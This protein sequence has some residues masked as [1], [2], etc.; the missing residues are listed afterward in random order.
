[1]H[2][3][4]SASSQGDAVLLSAA[5]ARPAAGFRDRVKLAW[6]TGDLPYLVDLLIGWR[7]AILTGIGLVALLAFGGF[8][9]LGEV[10]IAK[11]VRQQAAYGQMR[12]GAAD[13]RAD[14]LAMQT[15]LTGFVDQQNPAMDKQLRQTAE[16]A[17][18][19]LR[20]MQGSPAA[21]DNGAALQALQDGLA[22]A[23]T[24]FDKIGKAEQTLGLSDFEGL[25]F[26]LNASIKAMQSELDVWPNQDPL[27]ARMLQMR[28]AEKDFLLTKDAS[29]LGRHKRW[30]NEVDLKIDSGGLDPNT[31]ANFHKLLE[32][33]LADWAAYGETSLAIGQGAA[34]M[35][36][37]F[38]DLQPKVD[39]LFDAAEAASRRANLAAIDIRR[40]ML[41]RTVAMGAISVLVFQLA[42]VIFSRSITVP[43]ADMER[44]MRRLAAGDRNAEISGIGRKDEIGDMAKAVQVFKDNMAAMQQM[45]AERAAQAEALAERGRLLDQLTAEFDRE[46]KAIMQ[47]VEQSMDALH[48]RAEAITDLAG[49]T[50]EQMMQIDDSSRQATEGV[51]S[52]AAAAET[53]AAQVRAINSQVS[54]SSVVTGE[55]SEAASRTDALVAGLSD[56]AQSIGEVVALITAIAHKTHMLALNAT[57][58]SVR[59]GEAGRG[60]AIVA[61]EVKALSTQTSSATGQISSHVAEI[62]ART[63]QAVSAI[64]QI[65]ATTGKIRGN[66][67]NITQAVDYQQSATRDIADNAGRAAEGSV[68]V[69]HKISSAAVQ[70]RG[71]GQAAQDML[72]EAAATAQR[73]D[74]LRDKVAVFL[75]EVA[76]LRA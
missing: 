6:R 63:A 43:I 22:A 19:T 28:L 51:N 48:E 14:L 31:R 54:D 53:L 4:L 9:G 67:D 61:Q 11:A 50:S 58:E 15:A 20:A 72:R 56:S 27:V 39:G 69:S 46:A 42:A 36:K 35:R 33:Y 26:K 29:V 13:F 17:A 60:F 76:R 59:A 73:T 24:D 62:Q 47:A 21:S 18:V 8:Y 64:G 74:Q 12:D 30:A 49:L 75:S 32:A 34:D 71:M 25:R 38:A 5:T 66:A 65:V 7:F 68:A 40:T 44:S 23:M 70:A 45:Q 41:W 16:R 3:P 57:I 10:L 1:M 52:I 2:Q 37:I 55:A